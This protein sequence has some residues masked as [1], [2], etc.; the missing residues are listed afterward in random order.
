[1]LTQS[2]ISDFRKNGFVVIDAAF[3][4]QALEPLRNDF[5][6]WVEESRQHTGPF[7]QMLDGRPRFDVEPGHLAQKPGLRRIAAPEEISESYFSLVKEGPL[8][9]AVVSLL[10]NDV[11]FHH[12]KVNSKLPGVATTVKWHQ[13]FTFDP[14][15]NDDCIT[16]MLFLD[17]VTSENGAPRMVPGS[18]RG[19]L[20]SL[21]HDG[22]FTG[23]IDDSVAKECEVNAVECTG[24]A[25][26]LCL[27][28]TR[29]LHGSSVNRSD[30]PRTLYITNL[31]SADAIP[32]A[33]NAVPSIHTGMIA[34]GQEPGRI[35]SIDYE[36][37]TPEVPEGASFFAQQAMDVTEK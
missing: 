37:E 9:D 8:I 36:M 7:G 4:R 15:S 1:M 25:G 32:L 3:T 2:Q 23:A 11:R 30:S 27:M 12:A 21:W 10:G 20:Y 34:H 13:D 26:S 6:A 14:H 24:K 16:T 19:P 18:H 35:R 31:T 29:M 33:T 5:N 28:H 17:D 22:V